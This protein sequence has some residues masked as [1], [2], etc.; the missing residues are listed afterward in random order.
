MTPEHQWRFRG[1]R[2]LQFGHSVAA[3]DDKI[4]HGGNPVL[5]WLQ[6]GHSVAAVD[7]P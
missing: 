3:V 4:R 7:N 1:G 2:P 6:F 5:R